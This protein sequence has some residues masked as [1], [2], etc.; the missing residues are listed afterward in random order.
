MLPLFVERSQ[1]APLDVSVSISS[2]D[3]RRLRLGHLTDLRAASE[4]LRSFE[5]TIAGPFSDAVKKTFS[6]FHKPAPLL[7]GTLSIRFSC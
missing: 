4:H 1:G 6:H 2:D 3:A 5:A 7:T